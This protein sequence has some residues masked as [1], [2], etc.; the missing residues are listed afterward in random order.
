[1]IKELGVTLFS[2]AGVTYVT[3]PFQQDFDHRQAPE[4]PPMASAV[5]SSTAITATDGSAWAWNT[6][7]DEQIDVSPPY[8]VR[9]IRLSSK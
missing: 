9:A 1:M 8:R 6:M 5:T 4:S 2:I 7:A 3:A